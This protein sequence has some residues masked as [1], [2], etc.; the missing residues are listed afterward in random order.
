M[1]FGSF[2]KSLFLPLIISALLYALLFYILLPLYRRHRARYAQY[3]PVS[4][5]SSDTVLPN[6]LRNRVVDALVTFL[7]SLPFAAPNL[8]R[9]RGRGHSRVVDGRDGVDDDDHSSGE[10]E[11]TEAVWDGTDHDAAE[12]RRH[13]SIAR[14]ERH[15]R[16]SRDLEEGFRDSTDDEDEEN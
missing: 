10:E 2:L 15:R 9:W 4:L 7:S 12:S 13:E 14:E 5:A 16:L 11:L 6:D 1:G 3:L 8:G